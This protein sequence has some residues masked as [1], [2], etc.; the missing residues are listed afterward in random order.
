MYAII[1]DGG[2]QYRVEPGMEL[3]LDFRD[4]SA[5]ESITL[6]PTRG[7]APL[8]K[9]MGV[10]VFRIGQPLPASVGDEVVEQIRDGRDRRNL[11]SHE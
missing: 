1:V 10:W 11:E 8:T 7:M 3:D 5:G 9:E 2:R 4:L 6:R